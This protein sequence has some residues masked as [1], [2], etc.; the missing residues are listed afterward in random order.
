MRASERDSERA[1]RERRARA[2]AREREREREIKRLSECKTNLTC[3]AGADV[4][5]MHICV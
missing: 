5:Y 2:R 4:R 3:A 1:E